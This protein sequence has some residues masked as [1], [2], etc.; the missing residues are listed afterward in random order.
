MPSNQLIRVMVVD[1]QSIV[2]QGLVDVISLVADLDVVGQTSSGEKAIK[3]CH[4]CQPHVILMDM[5]MPGMNGIETTTAIQT[6]Y[7]A[8]QI[9]ILSACDDMATVQAALKAGAISYL[10]K[11]SNINDLIDAIR[12]ARAGRPTL[13]PEITQGLIQ[14]VK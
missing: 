6:T 5:L 8:A 4:T 7:P 1:D 2:R 12:A 13:S 10:L 9:I 3:L 14:T 11:N